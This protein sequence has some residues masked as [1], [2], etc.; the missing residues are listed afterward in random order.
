MKKVAFLILVLTVTIAGCERGKVPQKEVETAMPVKV[1]KV[2]KGNIREVLS[3]VGDIKAQE[4]IVIYSKVSGKL[5]EKRVKEGDRVKKGDVLALIDRDEVG[6]KFEK[7]PVTSPIDGTVGRVYLDKGTHIRPSSNMS[8][9]TPV[10]LVV[11]M[12]TVRIKINVIE[13]DFPKIKEGQRSEIKVDAYPGE[14]FTG[15]VERINPVIDLSSRTALAEIKIPNKDHRLKSG[16][17]GRTEV[18]T[19]KHEEVVVIPADAVTEEESSS[20]AFIVND[21]KAHKRK[22]TLGIKQGNQV[23]VLDGIEAGEEII[24]VGQKGLKDGSKVEVI[25]GST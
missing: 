2:G 17:F 23:Q 6:F 19:A 24:I 25:G 7:A 18:I 13:R 12:D 4:E 16:M 10:A 21:K 20:Y 3:Y 9:G 5:I 11:D 14:I 22:L 8:L 15:E 1:V